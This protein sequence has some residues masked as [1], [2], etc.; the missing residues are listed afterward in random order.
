VKTELRAFGIAVVVLA[1]LRLVSPSPRCA[2]SSDGSLFWEGGTRP[3]GGSFAGLIIGNSGSV[4]IKRSPE[5]V[6][7]D[8]LD[9]FS[10][11]GGGFG[12]SAS[13][14]VPSPAS[15]VIMLP[16]KDR[17]AGNEGLFSELGEE[18]DE[19]LTAS[20]DT[21]DIEK[22]NVSWGWLADEIGAAEREE[23]VQRESTRRDE[24]DSGTWG[25]YSRREASRSAFDTTHERSWE[26]SDQRFDSARDWYQGN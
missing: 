25:V 12:G 14:P 16:T 9:E 22:D 23:R 24:V 7:I 5:E 17:A 6:L 18:I 20:P 19:N 1:F 8:D 3:D 4:R 2:V 11:S 15:A 21:G 13:L 10:A 26:G